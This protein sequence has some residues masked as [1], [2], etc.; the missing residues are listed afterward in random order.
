MKS[1]R[2]ASC[3]RAIDV[4]SQYCR[5]CGYQIKRLGGR[6]S[7]CPKC[8]KGVDSTTTYCFHCGYNL[9]AKGGREHRGA[10]VL[11]YIV[12]VFLVMLILVV[13]FTILYKQEEKRV[14]E[15]QEPEVK[16]AYL[17]VASLTCEENKGLFTVCGRFSWSSLPGDYVTVYVPGAKQLESTSFTSQDFDYCSDAGSNGGFR[18][19]RMILHNSAGDVV[20]EVSRGVECKKSVVEPTTPPLQRQVMTV[21]KKG[22]FRIG[23]T[24]TYKRGFGTLMLNFDGAV[25]SCDYDGYYIIDDMPLMRSS[26]RCDKARG[27]FKG[28]A[29]TGNQYVVDDP[30]LFT[31]DYN[32][33]N[34][35]PPRTVDDYFFS[36]R[37]CESGYYQKEE[38]L[39]FA[40]ARISGFGA[41]SLLMSWEFKDDAADRAVDVFYNLR[42]RVRSTLP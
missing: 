24:T 42:C 32:T 34:D 38:S 26:G 39:N 20:D 17:D 33:K 21:A 9:R 11:K 2:C 41:Q 8:G 25:D 12:S 22:N 30:E 14:I 16:E 4:D 15:E 5:Y 23:R 6:E 35:P 28:S 31:W 10:H 29:D 19:V 36:M 37:P 40:R 18:V 27:T 3:H 1:V 7:K 13:F